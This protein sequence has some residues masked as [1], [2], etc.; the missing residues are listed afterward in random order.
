MLKKLGRGTV[1]T[2]NEIRSCGE[3]NFCFIVKRLL[4]LAVQNVW[5]GPASG[6]VY[7]LETECQTLLTGNE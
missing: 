4:Q 7:V 6:L 3:N 2:Q 1:N 5:L